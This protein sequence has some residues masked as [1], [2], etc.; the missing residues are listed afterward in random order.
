[1]SEEESYDTDLTKRPERPIRGKYKAGRKVDCWVRAKALGGYVVSVGLNQDPGFLSTQRD[2]KVESW[3]TGEF[4]C[5]S[6]WRILLSDR[7]L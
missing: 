5:V 1:M 3:I 7:F 2:V 4:V 6:N